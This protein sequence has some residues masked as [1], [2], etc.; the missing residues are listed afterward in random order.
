MYWFRGR[1]YLPCVED[2]IMFTFPAAVESIDG[3]LFRLED[4]DL[5]DLWLWEIVPPTI[6]FV[7]EL[8]WLLPI[9]RFELK[10]LV[11]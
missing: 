5:S 6:F 11:W 8:G 3:T 1:L 4:C 7:V 10:L 9:M 2:S